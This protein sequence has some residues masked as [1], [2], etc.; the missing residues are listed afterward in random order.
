MA[1]VNSMPHNIQSAHDTEGIGVAS[2]ELWTHINRASYDRSIV[3]GIALLY[4]ARRCCFT[5]GVICSFT[6]FFLAIQVESW[7]LNESCDRYVVKISEWLRDA[8]Y[9]RKVLS[10]ISHMSLNSWFYNVYTTFSC[11]V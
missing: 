5:C 8:G 2:A 6:G 7:P 9:L 10:C 4:I 3:S 1:M 11:T